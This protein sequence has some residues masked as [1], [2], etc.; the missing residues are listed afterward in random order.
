MYFTNCRDYEHLGASQTTLF[1]SQGI[2][3]LPK[4]YGGEDE[5]RS[6]INGL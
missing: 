1:N 3:Q 6:S 5:Q 2:M 4:I